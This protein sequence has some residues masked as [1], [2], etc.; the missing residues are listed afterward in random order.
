MKNSVR[1]LALVLAGTLLFAGCGKAGKKPAAE[2]APVPAGVSGISEDGVLEHV[3]KGTEYEL[4]EGWSLLGAPAFDPADGSLACFVSRYVDGGGAVPRSEYAICLLTESGAR[5]EAFDPE[6]ETSDRAVS[7]PSSSLAVTEDA[8]WFVRG[9][10]LEVGSEK[11][12]VRRDRETGEEEERL[13]SPLFDGG[14]AFFSDLL[15]DRDGDLWL[16]TLSEV[17]ALRPDLNRICS[18]KF[19][20]AGNMRLRADGTVFVET[21]NPAGAVLAGIDKASGQRTEE[22]PLPPT[23]HAVCFPAEADSPYAYLYAATGGV[24]G[25]KIGGKGEIVSELLLSYVNSDMNADRVTLVCA[26][27]DGGLLFAEGAAEG[28]G[29][30]VLYRSAGT[31][32]LADLTVLTVA[33]STGLWD[34]VTQDAVASF[35]KSHDDARIVLIDYG[36]YATAED[37]KAGSDRLALDMA[38]GLCRPDIVLG[39]PGVDPQIDLMREKKMA[40]D[41]S[42]FLETDP[43]V[44]RETLL[45]CVLRAFDDGGKIWCLSNYFYF[46]T[47]LAEPS[48]LEA[49]GMAG[50]TGWTLSEFLDFAENLPA[51]VE[52]IGNLTRETA[53]A[54]ILGEYGL[55]AF[56]DAEEGIC[57]FSGPDFV[58]WLRF[59][60]SLP[61][62]RADLEK[63]SPLA[64]A[65]EEERYGLTMNGKVALALGGGYTFDSLT[66]LESAFG[67]KDWVM[68]GYPG[69][70]TEICAQN[71][72]CISSSCA[73]PE[74]AWEFV[75]AV[76]LGRGDG[77]GLQMLPVLKDRF[78]E[79]MES[80][81]RQEY[82]RYFS[83][84]SSAG[85]RKDPPTTEADLREPGYVVLFNEEDAARVTEALSGA[86]IPV[87]KKVPDEIREIVNE[88]VSA[89]LGG[90]GTPE[91]CAGKIQSRAAIWLA[92]RNG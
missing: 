38:A 52:L 3:W 19:E 44:S 7:V 85:P 6:N 1:R 45:P 72:V 74:L 59:V 70:G 27:A 84:M 87:S 32:D 68:L 8:Y 40:L 63:V 71:V 66:D 10:L 39:R 12:L 90:V 26:A 64:R 89:F 35:N 13:L 69:G 81:Y 91:D 92:E 49:C 61:K 22:I 34:Q 80:L 73:A 28:E 41:L 60:E 37:P 9:K 65:S 56:F 55:G 30:P 36:S 31:V 78:R 43:E 2:P 14:D 50:K 46:S 15:A 18:A 20:Y 62:D 53:A 88:E 23:K 75:R 17:I 5:L 86:G 47:L 29:K 67:R 4:P 76:V 51:G 54:K 11:V 16:S 57:A 48:V 21:V 77:M 58:R 42:P 24:Y 25:A 83:G 82:I 79:G 33:I